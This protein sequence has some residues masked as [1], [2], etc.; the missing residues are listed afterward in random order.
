[1]TFAS[2]WNHQAGKGFLILSPAAE[3]GSLWTMT[4]AVISTRRQ[5]TCR[6]GSRCPTLRNRLKLGVPCDVKV[7]FQRVAAYPSGFSSENCEMA[8]MAPFLDDLS[9][10]YPLIWSFSIVMLD[11]QRVKGINSKDWMQVLVPSKNCG[12]SQSGVIHLRWIL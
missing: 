7:F 4:S 5:H 8:E 10:I 12:L 2:G 1:M 11:S 6:C 9:I 3:A